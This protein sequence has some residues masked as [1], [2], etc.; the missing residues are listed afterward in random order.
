MLSTWIRTGLLDPDRDR[1]PGHADS[2][3]ADSDR[4]Q[5]QTNEK[6]YKVNFFP[7]NV[8]MLSKILNTYDT[9]DTL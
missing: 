5:L 3:S 4:Y 2:D 6:V 9:L 8:N 7:E 1:H